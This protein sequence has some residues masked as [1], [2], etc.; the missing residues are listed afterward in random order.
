MKKGTSVFIFLTLISV[1][2]YYLFTTGQSHPL[3]INNKFGNKKEAKNIIFKIS[4]EKDK[5]ISKNKKSIIYI[6]GKE[7]KFE[8]ESDGKIYKG[9]IKFKINKGAEIFVE[10]FINSEKKWRQDISIN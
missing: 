10:K 5:K 2:S 7:K 4:G 3:L 1:V 6:K 8:I 9:I